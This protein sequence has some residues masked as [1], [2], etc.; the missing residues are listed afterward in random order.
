[1]V[2]L[3]VQKEVSFA[4]VAD[5]LVSLFAVLCREAFHKELEEFRAYRDTVAAFL[6]ASAAD[7]KLAEPATASPME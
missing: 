1:M 6:K 3:H 4:P 5:M 2:K 7:T